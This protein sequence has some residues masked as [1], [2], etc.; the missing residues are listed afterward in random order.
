MRS[1]AVQCGHCEEC[2]IVH[3]VDDRVMTLPE[4]W[5][6]GTD[7]GDRLVLCCSTECA[8]EMDLTTG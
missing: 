6:A 5:V 7:G 1:M 8:E 4:G 3:V 2:D